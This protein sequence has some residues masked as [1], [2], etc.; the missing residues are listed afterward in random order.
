M[1]QLSDSDVQDIITRVKSR[2]A[3]SDIEGKT[4]AA[5]VARRE[6]ENLDESLG[7]GLRHGG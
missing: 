6:I 7:E 4:G 2:V 5:L 3:A 1:P